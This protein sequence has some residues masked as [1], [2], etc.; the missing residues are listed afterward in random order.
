MALGDK[1]SS[2]EQVQVHLI[3]AGINTRLFVLPTEL[4]AEVS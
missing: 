1:M 4:F 3:W 2:P